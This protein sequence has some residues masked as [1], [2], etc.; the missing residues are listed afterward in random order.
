MTGGKETGKYLRLVQF[1]RDF[2]PEVGEKILIGLLG[3]AASF[4]QAF[5]IAGAIDILFEKKPFNNIIPYLAGAFAA[6]LFR[7]FLLRFHE[8][9]SKKMAAKVKGAIRN[10][11]LDK[12]MQMGP[13][14]QND[15]RSGNMQSLITDGVESLET[16]L[17]NYIPQTAVVLVSVTVVI[18]YICSLDMLVGLIILGAAAFSILIPHLFMPAVNRVMIEYWQDYAHL[19]AQYIEA[20]Q[21]M[22]TLKAFHASKNTLEQLETDSDRFADSSI[23]NTG[24]SLTDSGLITL[25]SVIGTSISVAAAAWHTAIGSLSA[26]GLLVILFLAGEC[27]KSLSDLNTYWHGSYLGFS[28]AEH[29]YAVLDEPIVLKETGK[30]KTTTIS[31]NPPDIRLEKVTFCYDDDSKPA[32][33][34]V[35]MEIA[36]GE[37]VAIVGKSGSGKSTI[38]NL[39]LRFFDV[40]EGKVLIGGKDIRDFSLDALRSQIAV[41]FQDTYLFY[42]TLEENLRMAKP[43]ASREEIEKAAMS[44]GAHDFICELPKGYGTIVGERGATLSGGERQRLSIAR[45]ILKNAP[46]LVL[47]E[48]T[49]SVDVSS[50]RQIQA[51]LENL[52]E[53]RTTIMIAHRLSTVM[54][55]SKIYVLNDGQLCEQGS[56]QQLL[57]QDGEYAHLVH[58]QQKAGS[59]G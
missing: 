36:S 1:L 45:A 34:K 40:K 29:L 53:H 3:T 49:S 59:I 56:H 30:E 19:N 2:K 47:D 35:S 7:A 44:A 15:K 58:I 54:D 51:A 9:Y 13:A 31:S 41:V 37:K 10:T 8:G 57:E 23:K 27:M 48:A 12:L 4:L 6:I 25:F 55:A 26:A 20:M 11:L 21:G 28:I 18:S 43:D 50:E 5:M 16:F 33:D 46:I 24:M 39:L 38:V 14:Y 32:L 42:G 22:T 52:M 17:V